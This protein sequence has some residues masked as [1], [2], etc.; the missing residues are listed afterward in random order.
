MY[1]TDIVDLIP[2]DVID[3]VMDDPP[4]ENFDIM[5]IFDELTPDDLDM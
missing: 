4:Y 3:S 5:N 1:K 2:S